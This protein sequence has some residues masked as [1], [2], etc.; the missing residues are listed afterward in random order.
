M[1]GYLILEDGTVFKGAS[2]GSKGEALGE[3]VF[4][5]SL[6]G[7]QEILTDPSYAS[8]IIVMTYP[9]I[10]NY[11]INEEDAES[12][13]LYLEGLVVK[14]A[15]KYPSNFT[16]VKSLS[17]YLIENKVIG[18]EKIDTRAL[19]RHIRLAGSMKAV[20][21]AGEEEP[22]LVA[23]TEKAAKWQGLVDLDCV[24]GVTCKKEWVFNGTKN[25]DFHGDDKYHIVAMDFGIKH[26]ILRILRTLDCRITIVPANTTAEEILAKNPDGIFLSNGPGDPAAVTY[27]I[28]TIRNLIGKLPIFGIC[29]GH[30]LLTLALGGKTYKL[31]FGH[32]G[33]NQP[34]RNELNKEIE[35][36]AQNHGFCADMESLKDTNVKLT[37]INL[38]D[39][40]C[41]GLA[42][43]SQ[44]CFSVQ[45]H[46]EASPGPHDSGYLFKEFI[47]IIKKHKE[48]I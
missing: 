18:I 34:V 29:L 43:I 40:T 26:N 47:E 14:E 24:E 31:K 9:L 4:N 32:H 44:M 12:S 13:G 7:Y 10:G 41:E 16:S 35:I 19:T 22:D 27:A 8:Q 1:K 23:L 6:S 15:C 33:G 30:Q 37:H 38:N 25:R 2:F 39:N 45:Y 28:N 17:E 48:K 21:Y 11:G 46:P 36:T 3:I 20:L 42:D 5:T